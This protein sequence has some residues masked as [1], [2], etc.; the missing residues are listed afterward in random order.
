ME[1]QDSYQDLY[2]QARTARLDGRHEEAITAYKRIIERLSELSAET[3]E[4][5]P[6]LEELLHE[7]A[8]ELME[9]LRWERRYDEGIELEEKLI[10]LFPQEE[11]VR[12]TEIANMT[13]ERGQVE[14]GLSLLEEIAQEDADNIWGWITLGAQHLWLRRY[15]EGETYLQRAVEIEEAADEDLAF[16]YRYL[17]QLYKEQ[18]RF[19]E[20]VAAWE[21]ARDLN[22]ETSSTLPEVYRMFIEA[23]D[24]KQAHS[25]LRRE[26]NRLRY[27]FHLGLIDHQRGDEYSAQ[28]QWQRLADMDPDNYDEGHDE[29]AEASLRMGLVQQALNEL[30]YLVNQGEINPRR[31]MLLGLAWAMAGD[32]DRAKSALDGAVMILD[33]SRPRR[34]KLR[35]KDWRL[36]EELVGDEEMLEALEDYFMPPIFIPE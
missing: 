21:K 22:P 16:A 30:A 29:W 35:R 20:A 11:L 31:M 12:R 23:G 7:T 1:L 26:Q 32:A 24:F 15:E 5:R 19:E 9:V 18:D 33:H 4:E 34:N 17:F 8:E 27:L 10:A 6:D 2:T 13:I 3:L 36:F 25:Y 28:R 14:E